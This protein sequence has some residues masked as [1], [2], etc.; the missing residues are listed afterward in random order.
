MVHVFHSYVR[1][2]GGSAGYATLDRLTMPGD[3]GDSFMR[4]RLLFY[5]IWGWVKTLVPGEP[6]NS[7]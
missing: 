7:W 1:C 4:P 2:L 3:G 5:G 6:Q